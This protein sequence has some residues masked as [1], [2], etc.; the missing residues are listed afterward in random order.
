MGGVR[1][2]TSL[3]D[4]PSESMAS[5]RPARGVSSLALIQMLF[6]GGKKKKVSVELFANCKVL[7]RV[8]GKCWKPETYSQAEAFAVTLVG[9]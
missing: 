4:G 9:E 7:R 6:R 3:R 5:H 2:A 8:T 1:R